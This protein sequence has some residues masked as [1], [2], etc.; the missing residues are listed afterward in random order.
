VA[1]AISQV[2]Q[3]KI[4]GIA[5]SQ[6]VSTTRNLVKLRS[7]AIIKISIKQTLV[8]E[9]ETTAVILHFWLRVRTRGIYCRGKKNLVYASVIN[10]R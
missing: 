4:V 7:I 8:Q 1:F 9:R 6:Y 2:M 5:G 3:K 10:P